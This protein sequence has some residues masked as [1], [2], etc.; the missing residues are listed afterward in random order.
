M[1]FIDQGLDHSPHLS[2]V[3]CSARLMI[4]LKD[5]QPLHVPLEGIVGF[6]CNVANG[7]A[8]FNC[9]VD[10]FVIHIGDVPNKRHVIRAIH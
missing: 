7:S 4:G 5:A 8:G 1:P 9:P 6:I 10:N 3:I 2:N